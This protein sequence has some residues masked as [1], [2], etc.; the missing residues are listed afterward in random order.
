[1]SVWDLMSLDPWRHRQ[2]VGV[3]AKE[4]EARWPAGHE[5]SSHGW[6]LQSPVEPPQ[7]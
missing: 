3:L 4:A 5:G 2:T 7:V 6:G 1:M